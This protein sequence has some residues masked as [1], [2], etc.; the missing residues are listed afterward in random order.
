MSTILDLT[1][2]TPQQLRLLII[3]YIS[4]PSVKLPPAQFARVRDLLNREQPWRPTLADVPIPL[5]QVQEW[6][7]GLT[8]WYG[9]WVVGRI[10]R[11]GQTP[12]LWEGEAP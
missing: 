2:L 10:V 9:D 8:G 6:L 1:T 11:E 3:T 12:T 7:D 5:P 4:D